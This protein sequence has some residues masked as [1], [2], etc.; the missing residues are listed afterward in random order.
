M[1]LTK[2]RFPVIFP[3]ILL[4]AAF[5]IPG[6][7]IAASA[8]SSSSLV[9]ASSSTSPGNYIYSE[10]A[11]SSIGSSSITLS[12]G[13]T[14]LINSS[15]VCIAPNKMDIS[16]SELTFNQTVIIA[17]VQNTSGQLVAVKITIFP[18]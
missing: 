8:G 11:I 4:A 9:L 1:I 5:I 6:L 18:S 12:S 2:K 16:C 14:Y 15:T 10:G 17:A 13:A 3:A 7:P